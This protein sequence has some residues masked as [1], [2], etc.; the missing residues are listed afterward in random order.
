MKRM[1]T[2]CGLPLTSGVGDPDRARH[3][4]RQHQ[5]AEGGQAHAFGAP[6]MTQRTEVRD[7]ARGL[8]RQ[9][10]YVPHRNLHEITGL[11]PLPATEVPAACCRSVSETPGCRNADHSADVPTS[12]GRSTTNSVLAKDIPS[13]R[14]TTSQI[15]G[16][17]G[18]S[19]ETSTHGA[20]KRNLPL[21][22]DRRSTS[23]GH[24]LPS[25]AEKLKWATVSSNS[26]GSRNALERLA[27]LHNGTRSHTDSTVATIR[28]SAAS[29]THRLA[30]ILSSKA[31]STSAI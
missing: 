7:R 26:S 24:T 29:M 3:Q 14:P 16:I 31:P 25:Y 23:S 18:L 22:T 20:G 10:A 12:R 1:L 21:L 28:A 15:R 27:K 11:N 6:R 8:R 19:F 13:G 30:A 9:A 4:Q 17:R 5:I 2:T